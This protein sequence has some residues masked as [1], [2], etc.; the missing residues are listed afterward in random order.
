MRIIYFEYK[1]NC[2]TKLNRN[3]MKRFTLTICLLVFSFYLLS[4][5]Y[6]NIKIS[7]DDQANITASSILKMDFPEISKI[8]NWLISNKKINLEYYKPAKGK[9]IIKGNTI[10]K[11][12]KKASVFESKMY[13]CIHIKK[14]NTNTIFALNNIYY[15]TLPQYGKQGCPA[16]IS[17]PN[18]WFSK[19][20]L[21]KKS[22]KERWLNALVKQNTILKTKE[23]LS[24]VLSF[25]N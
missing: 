9:A 17:Y 8:N 20:N 24:E 12:S 13:F 25:I 16:I 18:D 15:E 11:L 19:D 23:I 7:I 14:E 5:K 4:Q 6:E 21:Y 10:I 2:N 1:Y 22:G 3:K